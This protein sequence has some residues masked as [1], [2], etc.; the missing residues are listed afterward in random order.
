MRRHVRRW[1][2]PAATVLLS[3]AAVFLVLELGLRLAYLVRNLRQPAVSRLEEEWGWRPTP[4]LSIAYA[5]SGYGEI[6]YTS[7]R[8]GFRRFG[9]PGTSKTKVW[10]IGDS[11][12]QAYH[13]TDGAA[14]YDHLAA[15]DPE[16]ELFAFGVGGYGTLQQVLA[17]ERWLPE[18]G[19]DVVLWQFCA[20]DLINNDWRLELASNENNNHMRRPYLEDG[21]VVLRHPDGRLGGLARVSVLVRRLAILRSSLRK[22]GGHTIESEL[23]IEHPALRR[24][25]ATTRELVERVIAAAPETSFLAFIGPIPDRYA[26]ETEAFAEICSIPGLRCIPGIAEELAAAERSGV[27][28]D[29][30]GSD[31]HWN[32]AGHEIAG[33][34]ILDHLRREILR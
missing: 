1:L 31:T 27:A 13:V 20:N 29:G 8:D 25:L 9:D 23:H 21:R 2:F 24:S 19:P 7:T 30:G 14:Y 4:D 10:A 18:I 11:T 3:C 33:R 5:K 22:R 15:S 17:L 6:D 12:T 16:I 26:W 32:A 28:I 34:V